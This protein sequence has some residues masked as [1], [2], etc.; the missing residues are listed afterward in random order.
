M[1]LLALMILVIALVFVFDFLNGFHDAAN[2]VATLV[3]TRVLPPGWAV[4]MAG[5]AN[6]IGYFIFGVAIAKTVGEGIIQTDYATLQFRSRPC[7]QEF[8]ILSPHFLCAAAG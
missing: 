4:L 5:F 6:F 3:F 7:V 1:S 8:V 2:S